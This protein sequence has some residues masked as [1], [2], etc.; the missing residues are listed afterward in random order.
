M[1]LLVVR[2]TGVPARLEIEIAAE[3]PMLAALR[4][5]FRRWMSL[6]G[7]GEDD[8]EDAILAISEACSN[9]IEHGYERAEG[10]IHLTIEHA[11]DTLQIVVRDRGRWRMRGRSAP[12]RGR[13]LVIMRSVMRTVDV[14]ADEH[15]TTITLEKPLGA[16]RSG[17][18]AARHSQGLPPR[19]QRWGS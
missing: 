14:A 7:V 15:G 6:R 8:R 3:A 18:S 13:G 19:P 10:A 9:S 17:A 5:R 4:R 16:E 12:G 11:A 1:A 2:L